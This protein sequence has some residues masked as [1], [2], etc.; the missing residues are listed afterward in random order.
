MTDPDSELPRKYPRQRALKGA[1]MQLDGQKSYDVTIRDMSEGGVKLKL[2]SPFAVPASFILVIHN[3]NTGI[4]ERRSC[5]T[6]WQ[7][8]DQV[9][10][11]FVDHE[12]QKPVTRLAAPS[13]R[14]HPPP[15]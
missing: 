5:E 7:R 15:E 3:P 8:G 11:Q 1:R 13:L 4:S 12:P 9:G 2:G 10:A 6:R 14:R